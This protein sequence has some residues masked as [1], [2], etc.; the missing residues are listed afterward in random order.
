VAVLGFAVQVILIELLAHNL[1][2]PMTPSTVVAV[3]VAVLHNFFWH[4]RWTW[5]HRTTGSNRLQR[6][7]LFHATN[8]L[9][10]IAGNVAFTEIL[11]HTST[12]NSLA[13]SGVSVALT[14]VLNFIAADRL[15]FKLRDL[16]ID[17]STK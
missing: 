12:M 10:S 7:A 8:G 14:G 2:W 16:R 5:R 13:R 17:G 1:A 3:E 4:E 9:T 15:V 11:L 6:L